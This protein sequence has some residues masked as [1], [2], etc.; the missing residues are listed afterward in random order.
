MEAPVLVSNTPSQPMPDSKPSPWGT[1]ATT[2]EPVSFAE[3]MSEQL[4]CSLHQDEEN[5]MEKSVSHTLEE[6]EVWDQT[7]GSTDCSND[8]I[9]A[10]LLQMEYDREHDVCLVRREQKLNGSRKVSVSFKN[11]RRLPREMLYDSD[12]GDDEEVGAQHWDM[13]EK[14]EKSSPAIGRSGFTRYG[15]EIT[16]KHDPTICSHRN[17]CRVMEFPPGFLTGDGGSF[18]MKLSNHVYNKLK[19][20]SYAEQR[21]AARLHDKKEKSTAEHSLDPKTRLILYKLVNQEVLEGVNGCI[22]VGKEASVFHAWGGKP[23]DQIVPSECAIKAFKTTLSEFKNRDKY[24]RDD[25]RFRER[26]NKQNPRKVI[27][28]WAEKEMHNLTR[29]RK[30]GLPCPEVVALKKHVLVMTFIGSDQKPAPKL[31]EAKL[32]LEQLNQAYSQT[33]EIVKRLYKDCHLVHADMSEYNLLWHNSQVWVIDVSQAVEPNHPRA[34]EF[35]LRDCTNISMFFKK[36]G[37]VD[38]MGPKDMFALV[39][40]LQLPGEGAEL[41]SEIQNYERDEEILAHGCSDK[42]DYFEIL[43]SKAQTK[44]T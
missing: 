5:Q 6:L 10:Q 4:A 42:S 15:G 41:L 43:F 18:D 23:A 26:F 35:L 25:Y 31:K 16:T 11:Y 9:L 20:H 33:V 39:S 36:Q 38:V 37:V 44:N 3:V 17:A 8:L 19:V 1:P 28:M 12:E 34:L 40:G 30:V 2:V 29:I 14:A 21:R 22:S 32:S 7:E 27:H 13:F 24:I